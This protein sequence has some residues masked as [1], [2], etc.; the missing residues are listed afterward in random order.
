ML[1]AEG[2]LGS[3]LVADH[4]GRAVVET[5]VNY[6]LLKS[7]A[8]DLNKE[9]LFPEAR[10]VSESFPPVFASPLAKQILRLISI[11]STYGIWGTNHR[12]KWGCQAGRVIAWPWTVPG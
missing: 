2:E 8:V 6:R 10:R 1:V 9:L 7:I 12:G 3:L 4:P 11:G 5:L